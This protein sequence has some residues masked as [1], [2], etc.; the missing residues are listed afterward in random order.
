MKIS[1]YTRF[2]SKCVELCDTFDPRSV[3]AFDPRSVPAFD[4]R[5]VPAFDPRS[6]PALPQSMLIAVVGF[7]NI[8]CALSFLLARFIAIVYIP[9]CYTDYVLLRLGSHYVALPRRAVLLCC[10]TI[11]FYL[12][13]RTRCGMA[14]RGN[15]T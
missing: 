4:P 15:A 7:L 8:R 2:M 3:P 13:G 9:G 11:H 1:Q 5:S 14:R 6:V 12:R 10:I